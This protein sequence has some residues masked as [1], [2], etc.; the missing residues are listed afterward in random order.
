MGSPVDS[1]LGFVVSL[2]FGVKYQTLPGFHRGRDYS[3]RKEGNK[4]RAI[5]AG[6][7]VHAG[8]GGNGPAY[9]QHVIIEVTFLGKRYYVNY[10][11]LKTEIVYVGQWISFGQQIGTVGGKK[12]AKYSGTSTGAHVHVQVDT[13]RDYRSQVDPRPM[14][15]AKDPAKPVTPPKPAKPVTPW[16][17]FMAANLAASNEAYGKKTW[18]TRAKVG[19]VISQAIRHYDRDVLLFVE[20]E[21]AGAQGTAFSKMLKGIGYNRGVGDNQRTIAVKSKHRLG[22]YKVVTLKERGPSND[23]K[24]IVMQEVFFANE[25][26]S[27]ALFVV[28]HFEFREGMKNGVKYDD[29]RVAQAKQTRSEGEWTANRWGIPLTRVFF[30]NDE[31][32]RSAVSN[33]FGTTWRDTVNSTTYG[34]ATYDTINNWKTTVK[35]LTKSGYRPDK[36]RGHKDRPIIG[37]STSLT[38]IEEKLS[39]HMPIVGTVG[40]L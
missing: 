3:N 7:V 35:S 37:A 5:W 36:F 18:D 17:N 34:N 25:P 2:D 29:V 11:H 27:P 13:K 4:V 40:K 26:N 22:R 33:A 38:W 6:R 32:S 15:A 23:D 19:G 39:D 9:G 20:A 12:G 8:Y 31:N 30:Y 10:A 21:T 24:Q 1:G 14:I 16:F 28:G